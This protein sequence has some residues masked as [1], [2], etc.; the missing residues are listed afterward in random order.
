MHNTVSVIVPS[1]AKIDIPEAT[2]LQVVSTTYKIFAA[3]IILTFSGCD[4]GKEL[5][6]RTTIKIITN[7]K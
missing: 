5:T 2:G 7:V 4:I 1:C 3:I 6:S